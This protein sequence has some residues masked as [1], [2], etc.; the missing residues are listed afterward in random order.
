MVLIDEK[1][2][3]PSDVKAAVLAAFHAGT[4]GVQKHSRGRLANAVPL[5][6]ATPL[7]RHNINVACSLPRFSH[8][9]SMRDQ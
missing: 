3:Q 9:E 7:V 8:R 5:Q 4:P 1:R 2:T 6:I